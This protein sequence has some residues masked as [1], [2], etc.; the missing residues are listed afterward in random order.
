MPSNLDTYRKDL[1]TLLANGDS[2]L[3]AMQAQCFPDQLKRAL[4]K[5]HG[6]K[7][8]DILKA[9]P[10]FTEAYQSWYSEAK[11][12]VKQVLPDRLA[13]F[14]RHYEKPRSRKELSNENYRIEDYLQGLSASRGSEKVVTEAAAIPH[15]RQQLAILNS[16]KARFESSLFDIRHLVQA[17]LFDSEL[18]AA[19][20]LAQRGFTRAAGALAGV[21]LESHLAQ[22]CESHLIK[23][24]RKAPSIA[25]LNDALKDAGVIDIPQWRFVQ[26]LADIRNLCDHSKKAEP[27]PQ[28]VD[29][30][31]AGVMRTT[32]TLF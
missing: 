31:I 14:V 24:A 9:L 18:G 17:D 3:L 26:H 19:R 22:V 20:E 11:A 25:N 6:D 32:K 10:S 29:D 30:L 23:V 5:A 8:E 2:L 4:T 12:L 1:D 13:D 27:T 15:F 28:Q 16:A 21:V 7:A